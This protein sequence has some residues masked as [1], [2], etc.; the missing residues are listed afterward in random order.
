MS[1]PTELEVVSNENASNV[2]VWESV[3]LESTQPWEMYDAETPNNQKTII[4]LT[5]FENKE[6]IYYA[7]MRNDINTPNVVDPIINGDVMRDVT[8][9]AKFRNSSQ[10]F[11][12]IF[13]IN[14]QYII[15]NLHN[16]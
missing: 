9:L 7:Y 4:L 2:K 15:S 11:V 5:D 16:R 6:N 10:S 3:S 8:L 12:K 14:F 1:W 13:A